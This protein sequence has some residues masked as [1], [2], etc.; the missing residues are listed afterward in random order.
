MLV[1]KR[2]FTLDKAGELFIEASE[3]IDADEF[4]VQQ[5]I[6]LGT[7]G[8]GDRLL[9]PMSAFVARTQASVV[10]NDDH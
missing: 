3:G 9:L 5:S 7:L 2:A 1:Q 10:L 6:P 8:T 4:T